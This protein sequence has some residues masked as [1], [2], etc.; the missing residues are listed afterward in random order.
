MDIRKQAIKEK[1]IRQLEKR[2]KPQR[3]DL[4]EFLLEYF[5]KENPKGIQELLVDDY[6]YII[7]DHLMQVIE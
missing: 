7:A 5:R 3:D 4:V 1:A 2:Y 6:I